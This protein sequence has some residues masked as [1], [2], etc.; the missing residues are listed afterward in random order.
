VIPSQDASSRGWLRGSARQL[1]RK[2]NPGNNAFKAGNATIPDNELNPPNPPSPLVPVYN[3]LHQ[4]FATIQERAPG[5]FSVYTHD[6]SGDHYLGDTA[7][8][9][10]GTP[11]GQTRTVQVP[12]PGNKPL[13][14]CTFDPSTQDPATVCGQPN[15]PGNCVTPNQNGPYSRQARLELG[16]VGC[17]YDATPRDYIDMRVKPIKPNVVNVGLQGFIPRSAIVLS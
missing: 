1:R 5:C 3:S 17:M 4:Q 8:T 12:G 13:Y 6:S 16:G 7:P 14:E 10:T 9:A 15:S 11:N 2:Y